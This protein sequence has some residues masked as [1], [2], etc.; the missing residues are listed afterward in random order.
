VLP[1]WLLSAFSGSPSPT[2]PL[3]PGLCCSAGS[4]SSQ[5]PCTAL[6]LAVTPRCPHHT[7]LL[8]SGCP[9]YLCQAKFYSPSM[10][11]LHRYHTPCGSPGYVFFMTPDP[12]LPNTNHN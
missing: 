3:D 4:L 12:P 8:A 5:A 9:L 1:M 11:Y 2:C 6:S 10:A 7:L